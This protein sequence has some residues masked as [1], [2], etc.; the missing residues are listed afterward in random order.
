MPA[1]LV[2]L[3]AAGRRQ[4]VGTDLLKA[5]MGLKVREGLGLQRQQFSQAELPGSIFHEL[6]QSATDT[7]ILV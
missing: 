3:V 4:I 5:S 1:A 2:V 7:L 6:D